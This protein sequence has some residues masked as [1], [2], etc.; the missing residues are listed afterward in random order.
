[1]N[2]LQRRYLFQIGEDNNLNRQNQ[3]NLG[4]FGGVNQKRTS[5]SDISRMIYEFYFELVWV[6]PW[7]YMRAKRVCVTWY[8]LTNRELQ[9]AGS[10]VEGQV[11]LAVAIAASCNATLPE[12]V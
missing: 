12:L 9:A 2:K 7:D 10:K 4:G 3:T 11:A 1:M 5:T 6:A 8:K